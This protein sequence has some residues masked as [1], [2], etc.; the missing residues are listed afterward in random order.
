M[1]SPK[2]KLLFL[3]LIALS[4]LFFYTPI[5]AQQAQE[6]IPATVTYETQWQC[7]GVSNIYTQNG[8]APTSGTQAVI[9][10]STPYDA[11]ERQQFKEQCKS[12]AAAQTFTY[13]STYTKVGGYTNS[14]SG[15][16][17]YERYQY[18]GTQYAT[19]PIAQVIS[20]Q[21]QPVYT[22]DNP[23]YPDLQGTLCFSVEPPIDDCADAPIFSSVNSFTSLCVTVDENTGFSCSY[24][25]IENGFGALSGT[26]LP[27]TATCEC[28]DSPDGECYTPQEP[29][30]P[31]GEECGVFGNYIWCSSDESQCQS[32]LSA[33]GG[34]IPC[35]NCGTVN[36]TFMCIA[37]DAPEGE[38]CTANDTRPEC[39]G[40]IEGDCPT[41]YQCDPIEANTDDTENRDQPSCVLNDTRPECVGVPEGQP[42]T[43]SEETAQLEQLNQQ[44]DDLR[45]GLG[46]LNATAKQIRDRQLGPED[47]P[48][49]QNRVN[50]LEQQYITELTNAINDTTE[51]DNF[52]SSLSSAFSG[53]T[54]QIS[55]S[56]LPTLGCA[57]LNITIPNGGTLNVPICET[58]ELVRPILAWLF[59]LLIISRLV[60]IFYKVFTD[61]SV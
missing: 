60:S 15:L 22:C 48:E 30:F 41:G 14:A 50:Q 23:Q 37:G 52:L 1:I 18:N 40:T 2:N 13:G 35:G 8:A 56:L 36:D 6:S 24:E 21:D 3:A 27:T 38:R 17:V 19:I 58:G 54:T 57:P 45:A 39:E 16:D 28:A 44:T 7:V 10:R 34:T 47:L 43:K 31:E 29:P 49:I 9:P 11:N 32:T 5:K 33:G 25:Q 20:Q 26:F 12:L 59:T 51:Q 53:Y 55:G 46:E 61:S 42:P 4:G